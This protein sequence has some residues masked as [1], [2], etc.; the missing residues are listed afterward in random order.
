MDLSAT[1][2]IE[3]SVENVDSLVIVLNKLVRIQRSNLRPVNIVIV[4]NIITILMTDT[5]T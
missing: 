2:K 1:W 5:T 3:Q 4:I